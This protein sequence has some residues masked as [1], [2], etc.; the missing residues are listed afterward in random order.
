MSD[1][2][3]E[4]G[5]SPQNENLQKSRQEIVE[6]LIKDF[7][8]GKPFFWDKGTISRLPQ[9]MVESEKGNIK[10][11][12]GINNLRLMV[13]ARAKGYTD[14]RWGT[15]KQI[16]SLGGRVKRGEKGTTIEFWQYT[17]IKTEINPETGKPEPIYESDPKTG[18]KKP[19]EVKLSPPLVKF[20]TVFNYEQTEGLNL[21]K[22]EGFEH[23]E[24]EKVEAME[25]MIKYSEATIIHDQHGRNF[26]QPSTD[27]IHLSKRNEFTS[28]DGYY[29]TAA[30]EIAHSTG[31]ENRL[32]RD[33]MRNNDGFGGVVYAQE[34]L[35]AEL[36]ALFLRQEYNVNYDESHYANHAAY[37]KSWAKKIQ[38]D[39]NELFKAAADAQ[40]ALDYIKKNMIERD[41]KLEQSTEKAAEKVEEISLVPKEAVEKIMASL[42]TKAVEKMGTEERFTHYAKQA[43]EADGG[44]WKSDTNQKIVMSMLKDG[45]SDRQIEAS[46]KKSPEKVESMSKLIKGATKENE[47]AGIVRK[48]GKSL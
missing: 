29:A 45:F 18:E 14:S 35:R 37:L 24:K 23:S 17:K 39:P 8:E 27:E 34:E 32:N 22:E 40:K 36:T 41:L 44:A 26:Y 2:K 30:H 38:E 20:Y 42:A 3:K 48:G 7:E 9:N 25:A 46:M 11:Y 12:R 15:Y 47:K 10:P 16:Q 21:K 5:K 28:L 4:V 31:A 33:T 19:V 6:K 13:A 1:V 43:L